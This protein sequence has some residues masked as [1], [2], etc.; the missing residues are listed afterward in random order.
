MLLRLDTAAHRVEEVRVAID[1]NATTTARRLQDIHS[2][3]E[4]T[5]ILVN[6]NM[7]IQ[8]KLNAANAR[9]KANTTND[10]IDIEA[11]MLAER[12]L[13]Q[14]EKHQAAVDVMDTKEH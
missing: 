13:E 6:S 2:T 10:P 11:A 12:M 8:L 7:G 9:F 3:G 4:K 5:H 1:S 14:H